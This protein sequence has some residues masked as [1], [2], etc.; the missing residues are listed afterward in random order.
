MNRALNKIVDFV[1][2]K[3]SQGVVEITPDG[4]RSADG[5][6]VEV[7][8]ILWGTGFKA[9]EFLMPMRVRGEDGRD[10]HQTWGRDAAAFMGATVPGFPNMFMVYGPNTNVIV[11]ANVVYFLERQIGYLMK[12]LQLLASRNYR[13]MSLRPEVFDEHQRA[14]V[15]ANS[16]RAWS[17]SHVN[18]WY[19]TVNGRSPIMWPLSTAEFWAGTES[20]RP[21]HYFL[22]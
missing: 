10:L 9:S 11:H 8:V 20:A 21:E 22:R 2:V 19:K 14:L 4:V 13:A 12:S 3:R 6:V 16:L 1:R 17:W 15:E 5:S 7:D 18:S